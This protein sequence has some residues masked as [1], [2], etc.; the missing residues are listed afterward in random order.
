[1][2]KKSTKTKARTK[3]SPKPNPA[4]IEAVERL[5]RNKQYQ[6]AEARARGLLERFPD[7]GG[8]YRLLIDILEQK[9]DHYGAGAAAWLWAR[10]RP[11]SAPAQG[12]LLQSAARLGLVHLML[13]TAERLRALGAEVPGLPQ[14]DPALLEEM[15]TMPDGRI[16]TAEDM[17]AF[18]TG[19]LLMG[20]RDF[21]N[22]IAVLQGV[23]IASARNNL[24]ATLFHVQRIEDALQA[25]SAGWQADADNL[26]ALGW[27]IRLRCYLGDEDGARGLV[28]PLAAATARRTDDLLM[29]LDALLFMGEDAA[30]L[31]AFER[32]SKQSWFSDK[33]GA[34]DAMAR[35]RHF[36]ACASARRGNLKQA[37]QYWKE[38]LATSDSLLVARDN[39]AAISGW[40]NA[41]A[42]PVMFDMSHSFPVNWLEQLKLGTQSITPQALQD[43]LAELTASPAY[44]ERICRAGDVGMR[45]LAVLLLRA[46][47]TRGNSDAAKRLKAFIALPIGTDEDRMEILNVLRQHQFLAKNETV[48]IWLK[49]RLQSIVLTAYEIHREV[50]PPELPP[51]LQ[52]LLDESIDKNANGDIAGAQ[53]CLRQILEQ[54]PDNRTT[55]GNLG[56]LLIHQGEREAG[57]AMLRRVI[58]LYPDYLHPRCNLAKVLIRDNRLDEAQ[59]LLGDLHKRERFHI[60]DYFLLI[61]TTAAL[62]AARGD[63]VAA[64]QM[65]DQL[66]PMVETEEDAA[67]LNDVNS[68]VIAHLPDQAIN[69]MVE[70]VGKLFKRKK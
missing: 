47:A 59:D 60:Q 56:Q 54:T 41:P 18:D 4:Q 65:V 64:K 20:A 14:P 66:E 63:P 51:H 70:Q 17:F 62:T 48:D 16:A 32:A 6:E 43:R 24:G 37:R 2:A 58:A 3:Q 26:F 68:M 12:A 36:A 53:A 39:L 31:A 25:F 44:L 49:G 5:L 13:S 23:E 29:Q 34:P 15:R 40:N 10:N 19:R 52:A 45:G 61:G 21:P 42:F 9:N 69:K 7:Y 1:M 27:L 38:A 55:L 50:E 22:A 57:E 30:A 67:Y 28:T 8:L 11:N 46:Q 33:E 35:V